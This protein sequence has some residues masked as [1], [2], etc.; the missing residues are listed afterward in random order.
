LLEGLGACLISRA[1]NVRDEDFLCE[2]PCATELRRRIA[3]SA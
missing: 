1:L 2:Y 3:G